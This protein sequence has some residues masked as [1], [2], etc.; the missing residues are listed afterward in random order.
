MLYHQRKL[1]Q[2]RAE[3]ECETC[4]RRN[5]WCCCKSRPTSGMENG[6]F[7]GH[8]RDQLDRS[9]SKSCLLSWIDSIRNRPLLESIQICKKI[10]K[11]FMITIQFF[12]IRSNIYLLTSSLVVSTPVRA[13]R[14]SS[15]DSAVVWKNNKC[16]SWDELRL[17]V[18]L[19]ARRSFSV[20][21]IKRIWNCPAWAA[22]L[23]E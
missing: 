9:L 18:M 13:P 11:E 20:S 23:T 2:G 3:I 10:Q 8:K 1:E 12:N 17:T 22:A 15:L 21:S 7:F 6:Q 19:L 16:V 5:V 4:P 14:L